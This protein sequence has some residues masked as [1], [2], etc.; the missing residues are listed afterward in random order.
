MPGPEVVDASREGA[1]AAE[2]HQPKE[3]P[4]PER[5]PLI[6]PDHV[7]E[8]VAETPR[9]GRHRLVLVVKDEIAQ[10]VVA[11]IGGGDRRGSVPAVPVEG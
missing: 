7:V 8:V 4:G 11:E 9:R 2:E 5:P 10:G 3:Q 6:G 1:D